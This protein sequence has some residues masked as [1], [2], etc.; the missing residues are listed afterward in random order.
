MRPNVLIITGRASNVERM[1]NMIRN[2]DRVGARSVEVVNLNQTSAKEMTRI[3][4]SIY[5][6]KSDKNSGLTTVVANEKGNQVIISGMP[7]MIGRMKAMA[8]QLDAERSNNN[9]NNKVFYLRYARAETL[10][11]VLDNAAQVASSSKG[12]NKEYS[13]TAHE[14]NN[15]LVITAQPDMMKSLSSLIDKLDIRRAQVMVEAIIA[16]ISDSDGINL[17]VQLAGKDGLIQFNDGTTV[18]AGEIVRGI[19]AANNSEGDGKDYTELAAVLSGLS[20]SAFAVSSGDWASLIQA[21][22]SATESNVLSTPSLMTLDNQ[23][24]SFVVGDEVPTITGTRTGDNN[25]NPFQTIERR[26]VG[27]KLQV[28]P[29]INEGDAVRLDIEQEVS[30]VNGSTAVDVTFS[31]RE[32]KTSV[33][34]RSGDTV[35]ISG[36]MDDNVQQSKSKVPL[37]GD[38]PIL[39]HLFRSTSTRIVK[40]N[41]MVFIRPTI[42]RDDDMMRAVSADKYSL[43]R[44]SQIDR[45]SRG[46]AL[47]PSKDLPV[48]PEHDFQIKS[49][50]PVITHDGI[51]EIEEK[52]VEPDQAKYQQEERLQYHTVVKGNTLYSI[53]KK[54][55]TAVGK[56]RTMND[57][58]SNALTIGRKLVV[59]KETV[60]VTSNAKE[61]DEV[62]KGEAI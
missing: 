28:T 54:Y 53:A 20:G 62:D 3:L 60:F 47:M 32:V 34:V 33:M 35:V 24:A 15:A 27:V 44:A 52:S 21:V 46:I 30:S 48:L 40:R 55:G 49:I 16:E 59:G 11:D 26:T 4:S 14:D 29:Q 12:S 51:K 22:A 1:I 19:S 58:Q 39:G 7:E 23:P 50:Q 9:G 31:T 56:I 2:I 17:S 25:D 13:I 6:G 57:L 41:L 38:I 10:K 5:L 43:I 8:L 45:K 36:M 18:P 42:I 61:V 37:L